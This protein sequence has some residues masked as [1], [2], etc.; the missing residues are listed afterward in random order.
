MRLRSVSVFLALSV[1]AVSGL[2]GCGSS[3][4]DKVGGN[5]PGG[6]SGVGSPGAETA[7]DPARDAD[8][9]AVDLKN[10]TWLYSEGGFGVPYEVQMVDG[11]AVID[12]NGF[13]AEYVVKNVVYGDIDGDGDDDAAAEI[14]RTQSNGY[15][16]LWYIWLANGPEVVQVKYPITETARCGN[17]AESV[18]FGDGAL[19]VTDYLRIPGLD[20]RVPCSDHG[21]GLR[22]R[23]ITVHS[24][25]DDA[26]PVLTAPVAAWGGLCPGSKWD[27]SSPGL[28]DLWAAPSD[29]APMTATA[30]PDG[31]AMFELKEA[32]LLQEDGWTLIGVKLSGTADAQGVT[33]MECA[34]G[35]S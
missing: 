10:T 7:P 13:P 27:E 22:Q 25:G 14:A 19:D 11:A 21:T 30:G 35:A 24:E 17:F 12:E 15:K 26:W 34:W 20:D 32:P 5:P 6:G 2:T 4:S 33:P 28:A 23:S 1:L 3:A 16:A 18:V 9:H 31:G 29:D 8:I